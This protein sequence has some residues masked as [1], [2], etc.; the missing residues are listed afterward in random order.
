L[1]TSMHLS[2]KEKYYLNKFLIW[3][4]HLNQQYIKRKCSITNLKKKK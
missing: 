4:K 3:T 2:R 1:Q